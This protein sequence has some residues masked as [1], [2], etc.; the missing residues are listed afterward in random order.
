MVRARWLANSTSS[1]RLG[2]LS[3]QS[4]RVTRAISHSLFSYK[5]FRLYLGAS[6]SRGKPNGTSE[7]FQHGALPPLD[8]LPPQLAHARFEGRMPP[9]GGDIEQRPEHEGAAMGERM[10]QS[11]R[12]RSG[13]R[14]E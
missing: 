13:A 4:S 11:E 14:I 12:P 10:R 1:K 2:T 9:I 5:R 7:P 6:T 8:R 3:M